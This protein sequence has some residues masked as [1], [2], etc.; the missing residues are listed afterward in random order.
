VQNIMTQLEKRIVSPGPSVQNANLARAKARAIRCVVNRLLLAQKHGLHARRLIDLPAVSERSDFD[1]SHGKDCIFLQ[2]SL[3]VR[4]NMSQSNNGKVLSTTHDARP[5]YTGELLLRTRPKVYRQ[6]VRLFTRETVRAVERREAG[7]IS[8]RKK[9]IIGILS[10]VAEL[11]ASR[12]EETIGK[13]GLRDAAIGTGVAVDKMLAL[14]GQTPV[15]QIANIVM[16]TP[17][18]RAERDAA[19][20]RLDEIARLLRESCEPKP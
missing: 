8:A 10:N 5:R 4:L 20:R 14:T 19:H 6:I 3:P 18:E 11:G 17:E 9:S 2:S 1:D 13:A 12:M 16:P 7:E 15:V